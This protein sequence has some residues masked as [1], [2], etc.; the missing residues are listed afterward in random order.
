MQCSLPEL[1]EVFARKATDTADIC[2]KSAGVISQSPKSHGSP[3]QLLCQNVCNQTFNSQKIRTRTNR[4]LLKSL[5][6]SSHC[7]E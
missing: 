4:K 1:P 7:S 2:R 3:C 5:S 6:L